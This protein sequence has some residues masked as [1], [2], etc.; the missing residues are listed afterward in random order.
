M[1]ACPSQISIAW[2]SALDHTLVLVLAHYPAHV[3]LF[4]ITITVIST[5]SA[6]SYLH[7][8]SLTYILTLRP[9][10]KCVFCRCVWLWSD[11]SYVKSCDKMKQI[12]N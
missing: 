6:M 11:R 12:V 10:M 1:A 3:L 8:A 4:V 7:L 2:S 5:G 9:K